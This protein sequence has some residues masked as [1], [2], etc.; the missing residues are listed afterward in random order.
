AARQWRAAD[1]VLHFAVTSDDTHVE[2]VRAVHR[3]LRR[4]KIST[5]GGPPATARCGYPRGCVDLRVQPSHG[6]FQSALSTNGVELSGDVTVVECGGIGPKDVLALRGERRK[7][8]CQ[9]LR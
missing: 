1:R 5:V 6:L 4:G 3:R 9:T 2:R 8:I 7:T